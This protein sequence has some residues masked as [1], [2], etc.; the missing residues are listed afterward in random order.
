MFLGEESLPSQTF[1]RLAVQLQGHLSWAIELCTCLVAL[2]CRLGRKVVAHQSWFFG[3]VVPKSGK[4]LPDWCRELRKF[5]FWSRMN[6]LWSSRGWGWGVRLQTRR[7]VP[8]RA[9]AKC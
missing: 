3:A 9:S 4:T 2:L 5:L 1:G 6:S 8:S 7:R